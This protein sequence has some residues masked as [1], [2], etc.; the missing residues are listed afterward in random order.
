MNDR[1]QDLLRRK[2]GTISPQLDPLVQALA[3]IDNL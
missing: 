1:V 2:D 3:G